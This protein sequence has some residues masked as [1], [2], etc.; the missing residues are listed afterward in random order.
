MLKFM[1][2]KLNGC[3]F[4]YLLERYYTICDNVSGDIKKEFHG[5]PY[6][7]IYIFFLKTKIK[8]HGH[9]VTIKKFR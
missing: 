1:M 3:T 2:D 9:E 8:S 4:L 5:E 6:Y 7:N